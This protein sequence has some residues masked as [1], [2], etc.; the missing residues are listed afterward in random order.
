MAQ[1]GDGSSVLLNISLVLE[2]VASD[3]CSPQENIEKCGQAATWSSRITLTGSRW[4][5]SPTRRLRYKPFNR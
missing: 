2:S 3:P 5:L 4:R 1:Q